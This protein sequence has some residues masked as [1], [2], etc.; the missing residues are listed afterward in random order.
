MEPVSL[1]DHAYQLTDV[2][3]VNGD[4]KRTKA[5]FFKGGRINWN[6]VRYELLL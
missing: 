6:V 3:D 5:Y 1:T 2:I 4:N